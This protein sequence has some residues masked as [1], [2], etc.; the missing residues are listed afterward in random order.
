VKATASKKISEPSKPKSV[1][2]QARYD[3]ASQEWEFG[4]LDKKG[5]P[6]GEW[7]YWWRTTGHL[8]CISHYEDGGRKNTYSRFH[9]DGT[10]S[11]K[12]V[13]INGSAAPGSVIYYQKSKK[14]T[15]ELAISG[16]EYKK[17]FR[18]EETYIRKG[19]STWRNFDAK[20]RRIEMDGTLIPQLDPTKYSKNFGRLG[21]PDL[22]KKLVEF[23]NDVGI[24]MFAQG[25][26][27]TLDDK[28]LLK[29]FCKP[30]GTRVASKAKQK[31][32]LEALLPIGAANGTGSVYVAWNHNDA[33]KV[34]DMPIVVFG[35]EGGFHVVAEN[36]N[37]LLAIVSADVEPMVHWDKVDY[38]NSEDHEPSPAIAAYRTWLKDNGI[39][40]AS[41]PNSLVRTAQKR[42]HGAFAT[43]M[44]SFS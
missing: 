34:D 28:G 21:L 13:D 29:G 20:G 36:L 12:G 24:E 8:C 5:K 26:A 18:V 4:S 37:D 2:D 17:V 31:E 30:D 3:A 10:Y 7:R 16:P 14:P 35:D 11:C 42:Y 9:P 22:L 1:P 38:D 27:L 39:Q 19:L 33:T 25:F 40:R 23:Q 44:S 41:K 6:I 15:T 32:F 43:W